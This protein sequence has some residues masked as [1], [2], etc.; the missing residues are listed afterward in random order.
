[1]TT[2][3]YCKAFNQV[4]EECPVL[5]AKIQEKQQN[6]NVQFIGVEQWSPDP[7]MNVVTRSGVV[8]GGQLVKPSG[9]WVQKVEEKQ[10]AIDLSKIKDIFVHTNKEFCKLDPPLKKEK[11]WR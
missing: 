1:M 11:G 4:I 5:L 7:T 9:T 8:T 6:Q 2:Y 10:P 3:T